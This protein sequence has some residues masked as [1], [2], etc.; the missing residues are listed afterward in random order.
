MHVPTASPIS[1]E[2]NAEDLRNAPSF[3]ERQFPVAKVSAESFRERE[4]KQGQLLTSIGKWWG[5]K[6]LVLVRA[7]LL[8]CLLPAT[9]DPEKDREVFLRL[10]EMDNEGLWERRKK[11]HPFTVKQLYPLLS[12][13]E[14]QEVFT[15][16]STES[17]PK[18]RPR[19]PPE[20]KEEAHRIAFDRLPF[21]E[22]ITYCD[23]VE[24]RTGPAQGSWDHINEH[25]GTHA[26]D[27]QSLVR[28]LGIRRFGRVPILGD[29][30]CGAG[31]IPFEASH[32][33]FTAYASDLNP[34]AAL[35]TWGSLNII[36]GGTDATNE[37]QQ[38]LRNVY[39]AVDN[40]IAE[41]GIEHN[42]EG[43]R[44]DAF[45][46]CIEVIDPESGW[47]V[48]LIPSWVLGKKTKTIAK[49]TPIPATKSYDIEILSGLTD[50]E[51]AAVDENGTVVDYRL[52]PP[53]GGPSTP[54]E[55]FSRAMRMWE[56]GD[57]QPR[58]DDVFQDRL[59]CVRW[60][61]TYFEYHVDGAVQELTKTEAETLPQYSELILTGDLVEKRRRMYRS[62]DGSDMTREHLAR[63]LLMERLEDWKKKGFIPTRAIEPGNDINRPTNAR[64]WRFWHQ[65]FNPRQ[66]LT[67]GLFSQ[68]AAEMPLSAIGRV[69]CLYGI[70][71]LADWN[72]KQCRWNSDAANEKSEQTFYKP[73]LSTPLFTYCARGLYA[74][75]TVFFFD[76][77]SAVLTG[78]AEVSLQDGRQVSRSVDMWVTDPPYA[79][80]VNYHELSEYFLAW[81]ERHIPNLFPNWY[82]DSKR[83]LAIRAED[84][85]AFRMSMVQCYRRLVQNMADNGLQVVMFTHQEP[86]VWADLA[87]ILWASGLRVTAAWCIQTERQAAGTRE[88]NY[89]QGTVIMVLRKRVQ[90]EAVFL[91]EINHFIEQEVRT[92]LDSMIRLDDDSEPNFGDA[93]YQ[94]AAYAAA[95]RVLTERPIEE[96]DPERELL[97]ATTSESVVVQLIKNAVKIACDHLVPSGI[98]PDIWKQLGASERFYLKALEVESHSERRRG[99]FQELA[100]GFGAVEYTDLLSSGKANETRVKTSSEFASRSQ[101][102]SEFAVSLVRS[103]LF[104]VF[105]VSRSE[106]TQDGLNWLKT[107]L[108]DYWN[109]REKIIHLLEFFGGLGRVSTM[110]HWEKDSESARLLAGT[111][112]NDHV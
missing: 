18:Y 50:S 34:V 106:Q 28:E 19:V 17:A 58:C 88:G 47:R 14:R 60:V 86:S 99:V 46:Y 38:A 71:R 48:P 25:L 35:L 59:F 73:S 87:L 27:L 24:M 85:I 52:V 100:R 3:I 16:D 15:D 67:I 68:M 4:S 21:D 101:T 11:T 39:N 49:L 22:R 10:M 107:E 7:S 64:G 26:H 6:P 91:D 53:N 63:T 104:A 75:D 45:L 51:L 36:G 90:A 1:D 56:S 20:L 55:A 40:Q 84:P 41:W 77:K 76:P 29:A 70:G 93:D 82:T 105:K 61:E 9:D 89:V 32:I 109:S 2:A 72:S 95:L 43:W 8:G 97:R 57:L 12:E 78:T 81:Y 92:Q 108:Q 110:G 94:L 54:I 23:R 66:L 83:V 42:A 96:I 111:V 103:V 112:R 102:G 5:R 33:G 69:A 80:A 37:A 74:L 98:S 44:A 31:S 30:F 13:K 62:V 79:D 65:F